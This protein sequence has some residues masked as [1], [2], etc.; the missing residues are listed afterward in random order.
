MDL[1]PKYE[2][3]EKLLCFHGPLMYE[4]KCLDVK[5]KEDGVI[6]FVHYQGWNK[7][8]SGKVKVLRKSEL[9]SQSLPP[10]EVLEDVERTLKPGQV[11]EGPP[12]AKN[13]KTSRKIDAR[14]PVDMKETEDTKPPIKC[15]EDSNASSTPPVTVTIPFFGDNRVAALYQTTILSRHLC[16]VAHSKR[17]LTLT[18]SRGDR[19][20]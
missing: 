9:K 3:G 19:R 5:V 12:K 15:C 4:A 16:Y 14:V 6:Y 7:R 1:N 17:I 10:P 18:T 11:K 8:K 2:K 13:I 20:H